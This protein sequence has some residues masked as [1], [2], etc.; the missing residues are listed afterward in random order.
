MG[1]PRH[2]KTRAFAGAARAISCGPTLIRVGPFFVVL[3]HRRSGGRVVHMGP[4]RVDGDLRDLGIAEKDD[5]LSNQRFES[6][7]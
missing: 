2:E 6:A 5:V 1:F 3:P 7:T 4:G